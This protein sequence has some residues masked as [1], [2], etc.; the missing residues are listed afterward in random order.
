ML[1]RKEQFLCLKKLNMNGY[2]FTK[3]LKDNNIPTIYLTRLCKKVSIKRVA[4]G[5][6][7]L[8]DYIEDEFYI[9]YLKNKDLIYTNSSAL[10]LHGLTH[11]QLDTYQVNFFMKKM[12]RMLKNLI[13]KY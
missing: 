12:F 4:Y 9:N 2:I 8:S 10:Y 7:I 3:I 6:Y 1:V 13:I 5:I 11:K